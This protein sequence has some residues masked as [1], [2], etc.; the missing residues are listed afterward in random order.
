VMVR[1]AVKG[2][3]GRR[4]PEPFKRDIERIEMIQVTAKVYSILR[5]DIGTSW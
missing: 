5:T 2:F 1:T 4:D 3:K